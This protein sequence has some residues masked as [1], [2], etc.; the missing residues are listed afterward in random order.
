LQITG[1]TTENPRGVK[2]RYKLVLSGEGGSSSS[3]SVV[4][5]VE[6]RRKF[7]RLVVDKD[8]MT[9]EASRRLGTDFAP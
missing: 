9:F 3:A 7:V 8:A 2:V 5:S 4:P 6:P 1:F